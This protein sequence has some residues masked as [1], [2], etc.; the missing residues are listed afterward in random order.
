M[1]VKPITTIY[2]IE[3]TAYEI[4]RLKSELKYLTDRGELLSEYLTELNTIMNTIN[5]K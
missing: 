3:F 4:H 1:K 5:P 2:S